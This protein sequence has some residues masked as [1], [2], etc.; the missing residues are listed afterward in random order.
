[1]DWFQLPEPKFD[2]IQYALICNS[3]FQGDPSFAAQVEIASPW[4]EEIVKK[5]SEEQKQ[6]EVARISAGEQALSPIVP[7]EQPIVEPGPEQGAGDIDVNTSLYKN[8]Y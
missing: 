1:M 3:Q 8:N 6:L 4:A 2:D 5:P 7:Q